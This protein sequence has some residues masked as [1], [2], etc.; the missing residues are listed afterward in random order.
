M[1]ENICERII[2]IISAKGGA[3]L[4]VLPDQLSVQIQRPT[5]AAARPH[6]HSA[7]IHSPRRFTHTAESQKG[8]N[9]LGRG[10]FCGGGGSG[11]RGESGLQG[12]LDFELHTPR[13]HELLFF[14]DV[15][16]HPQYTCRYC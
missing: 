11:G 16:S 4:Q 8:Q 1:S 12:A 14:F 10:I 7:Q 13:C 5:R 6:S 2:S 9:F 3:N 15:K